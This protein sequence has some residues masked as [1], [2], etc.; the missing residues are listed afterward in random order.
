MGLHKNKKA[1]EWLRNHQQNEKGTNC[2]GKHICQW[3]LGQGF[4]FQNA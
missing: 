2:M 3:D 1:S 4:G